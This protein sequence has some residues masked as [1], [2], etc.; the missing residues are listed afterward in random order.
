MS[1]PPAPP[2]VVDEDRCSATTDSGILD[3]RLR[4]S[5][6]MGHNEGPG[7]VEHEAWA[8]PGDADYQGKARLLESWS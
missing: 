2:L 1:S 3:A 7:A 8:L 5:L 6:Q 4:C